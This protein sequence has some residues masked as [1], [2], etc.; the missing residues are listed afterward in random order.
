MV[1]E[2]VIEVEKEVVATRRVALEVVGTSCKGVGAKA[3][4][5]AQVPEVVKIKD[6]DKS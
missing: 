1:E 3:E 2:V 4:V 6:V 5:S